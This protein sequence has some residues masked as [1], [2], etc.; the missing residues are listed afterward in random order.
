MAI[1]P[2]FLL[3]VAAAA[4][5]QAGSTTPRIGMSLSAAS[6]GSALV[7]TV[8]QATSSA[9]TSKLRRKWTSCLA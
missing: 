9:F 8:P 5:A 3:R 4:A 1:S 7:D 6:T 2:T